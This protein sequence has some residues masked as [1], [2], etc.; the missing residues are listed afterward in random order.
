MNN[1]IYPCLWF[2]GK[3]SEAAHFYC[4]I[5][6]NSKILTDTPMVAIFEI[7][8]KK[9]MGLN[10][11]TMFTINP[12]ISMFVFCDSDTE[13]ENAWNKLSDGGSPMMPL[14]K[15]PWAE[16]Y[17]WIMDKYGMTWQLMLGFTQLHNSC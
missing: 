8:G 6:S 7:E 12:S 9:I 5:F 10:G 15:Y 17:G 14:E 11:G 1:H 2:D 4:S 3:A 16:K 13:I